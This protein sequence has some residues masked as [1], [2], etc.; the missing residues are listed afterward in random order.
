[1]LEDIRGE[2]RKKKIE[3]EKLG[4][5]LYPAVTQRTYL[6]SDALKLFSA[7]AKSKKKVFLA[8]RVM[9]LRVQGGVAFADL[10]DET[11]KIQAVLLKSNL[12]D[13]NALKNNLDIGDFLEIGGAL[14]KTKAGEKS[15]EAKSARIITKSLLPLPSVWHGLKDVEERYRKRHLDIL[16]NPEVR[17]KIIARAKIINYLRSGLNKEG[18]TE[19]ETPMLQPIPGGAK[20]RPFITHHNA[21]NVD[22]YLRIAPELYLKRLLVGGLEKVFE[23]GRVFRNEGVD[24]DHNPEF[25]MLE[26]YWAYR[27]YRELMKFTEK[28]LKKFIP[29]K[30][31][32]VTF[33]ELYKKHTGRDW[34]KEDPK[35]LDNV[36]KHEIRIAGKVEKTTFVTDYPTLLMPLAKPNKD[37]PAIT[38]SFQLIA[39]SKSGLGP[40]AEHGAEIVKG[41]SELND[42]A[43]QRKQMEEQEKAFR[44]GN[45]EFS[46]VDEE[47]LE[48]LEY[49]MP[50]AAGMGI[51]I[52]RLVALA[53]KSQ[54]LK[55][56]ILFPALRPKE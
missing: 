4:Y 15:V 32:T 24:R 14:F 7:L 54:S 19:V 36:Y 52:D 8:G 43:F 38:E 35:K 28:F 1:M 33:T 3:L 45:E 48:A 25:T 26:M 23:I 20:A 41:F 53:T 56:V 40:V 34:Q 44:A 10:K 51:G 55:E 17:E 47:F 2:R 5:S 39:G 29:G 27:D 11:G 13:F 31:Q 37:N 21:L 46:R 30:W 6:I 18:F 50:P 9:G 42:P 49:G 16:L 12:S 22:L